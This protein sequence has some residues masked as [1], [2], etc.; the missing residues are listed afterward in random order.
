MRAERARRG[1][2]PGVRQTSL[3]QV[4]EI[5]KIQP[6]QRTLI[7][8]MASEPSLGQSCGMRFDGRRQSRM[9]EAQPSGT[10]KYPPT[11]REE[12]QHASA[13]RSWL[14]RPLGDAVFAGDRR[15]RGR[16]SGKC[17]AQ[18]EER[19]PYRQART[20]AARV[21]ARPCVP[22]IRSLL[23]K[24]AVTSGRAASDSRAIRKVQNAT[25]SSFASRPSGTY[26]ARRAA[27]G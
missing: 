18:S 16:S 5:S 6:D 24:P 20:Q 11:T 25:G 26:C 8:A 1:W 10:L 17:R 22:E 27:P 19:R 12:R 7:A 21:A 13:G 15:R 14:A 4:E 2:R 3:L 9:E 23:K